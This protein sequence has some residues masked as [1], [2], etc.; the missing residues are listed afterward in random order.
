MLKGAYMEEVSRI[1]GKINVKSGKRGVTKGSYLSYF[2]LYDE[3]F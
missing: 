2:L 1:E 3:H